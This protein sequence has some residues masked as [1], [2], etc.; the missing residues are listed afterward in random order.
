L[1][2]LDLLLWFLAT[3]MGLSGTELDDRTGLEKG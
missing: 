3:D 1:R 2:G